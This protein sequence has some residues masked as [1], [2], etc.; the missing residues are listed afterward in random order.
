[1]E[2]EIQSEHLRNTLP[3]LTQKQYEVIMMYFFE[4]MTQEEIAIKLGIT[5]S[6][7]NSRLHDALKKLKKLL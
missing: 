1:M 5:R 7:V 3:E 6:A 4:Y 2:S